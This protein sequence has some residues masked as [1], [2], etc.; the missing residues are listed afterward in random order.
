MFDWRVRLVGEQYRE[1]WYNNSQQQWLLGFNL[2]VWERCVTL[3]AQPKNR[4]W[5]PT[6]ETLEPW[7]LLLGCKAGL[8]DVNGYSG[9]YNGYKYNDDVCVLLCFI[10]LK[11][12]WPSKLTLMVW[13]TH[14]ISC[15]WICLWRTFVSS[16]C[17]KPTSSR[18]DFRSLTW[19]FLDKVLIQNKWKKQEE[20]DTPAEKYFCM[21]D[22]AGLSSHSY[23]CLWFAS[24]N[25]KHFVPPAVDRYFTAL[26]PHG[27]SGL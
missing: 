23:F 16:R 2:L 1:F 14:L 26:P 11:H 13:C 18:S 24:S 22:K 8:M 25:R 9:V 6:L 15:S 21:L 20:N 12:L 10:Y 5:T 17:P 27:I 7:N 3:F 4:N 19:L